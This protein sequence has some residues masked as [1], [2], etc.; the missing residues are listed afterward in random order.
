[1]VDQPRSQAVDYRPDIDGLRAVAVVAVLLFHGRFFVPGGY[2]GVDVFFVIS[3]YLITSIILRERTTGTFTLAGFWERRIR[4]IV[5]LA[6]FVMLT[7]IIA[8]WF[9][10]LPSD[11]VL[12]A[13]SSI[14]QALFAGNIWFWQNTGYF[15]GI[16]ARMPL[17][18]TWSLAVEEQFYFIFPL[19]FIL[20]RAASIKRLRLLFAGIAAVSFA[21]GIWQT[22]LT[23][24]AAYFLLP[25]RAWELMAGAILAT[26]PVSPKRIGTLHEVTAAL[27]LVLL[28]LVLFLYDD[29]TPFP[30]VAALVPCLATVMIIWANSSGPTLVRRLLSLSLVTYVGRIS[31]SLYMWH[32]P[33]LVFAE[34]WSINPLQWP[35]RVVCLALTFA[36]AA[37]TYRFVESPFR[38]RR[39]LP[40]RRAIFA[41]AAACPT[42]VILAGF[43]VAWL[44]GAPFR[45]PPQAIAFGENPGVTYRFQVDETQAQMGE[46]PI[47]GSQDS[48]ATLKVAVWGDS[49]AMAILPAIDELARNNNVRVMV[50]THFA[51]PPLIDF[52]P[53]GN[54]SLGKMT[55]VWSNAVLQWVETYNI[56]DVL[57]VSRWKALGDA[58]HYID[59]V[60]RTVMRV[61]ESGARVWI[62]SEVP[63]YFG[64]SRIHTAL[65]VIKDE[66]SDGLRIDRVNYWRD[67]EIEK[68]I[69]VAAESLGARILDPA[70]FFIDENG[71]IVIAENDRMYLSDYSH[72]TTDGALLLLDLFKPIFQLSNSDAGN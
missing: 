70:P 41:F 52:V 67:R 13:Q 21:I 45:F 42:I 32:W 47:L 61:Q 49:H 68:P 10:L 62:M 1:M 7:T 18:H 29:E 23:P 14:A 59:A 48:D 4:R 69:L 9:V 50:A 51:T 5:P 43:S 72:L 46:F 55:P 40:H 58:S 64:L 71:Q 44:D 57:L 15:D 53:G 16:S 22:E 26:I 36:L 39:L 2:V 12:L 27:G 8:G 11:F 34:Y 56:Q 17:L 28:W 65:L 6:A 60:Q 3:G 24:S 19:L 66:F 20:L 33:I 54:V 37:L 30:G 38:S 25:S 31:Y 35:L 63:N